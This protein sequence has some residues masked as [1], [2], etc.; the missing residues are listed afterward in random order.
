MTLRMFPVYEQNYHHHRH[1]GESP[2]ARPVS[3]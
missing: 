2:Y 1:P 3:V